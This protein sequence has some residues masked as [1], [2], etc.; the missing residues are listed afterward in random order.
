[1]LRITLSLEMDDLN[2][3]AEQAEREIQEAKQRCSDAGFD[4][5]S[6]EEI[7]AAIRRWIQYPGF[8]S[9]FNMLETVVLNELEFTLA[10]PELREEGW[11]LITDLAGRWKRENNET[12]MEALRIASFEIAAE[13][14]ECA[15]T[16]VLLFRLSA[17]PDTRWAVFAAYENVPWR[18]KEH[19]KK[20][21]DGSVSAEDCNRWL[22]SQGLGTEELLAK[23]RREEEEAN[24]S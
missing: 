2:T 9:S 10:N 6:R 18:L 22:E 4:E 23:R 14:P 17:D 16:L 5:A 21:S 20:Y 13:P 8:E 11:Q 1:M 24:N 7:W 12:M 3:I 15:D 19:A